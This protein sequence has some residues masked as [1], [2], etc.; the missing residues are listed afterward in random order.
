MAS[1]RNSH[2][3]LKQANQSVSLDVLTLELNIMRATSLSLLLGWLVLAGL[4]LNSR[5]A[6]PA[7][8]AA[9][10]AI[11]KLGG[12]MS[13]QGDGW[14]VEF[15]HRGRALTDEGL[16]HVAALKNV[17]ALNLRDTK[18]T[19]AGLA[20]LK[21][22][23][24]LRW[25]HLERTEVGDAGIE[26]LASLDNL[27]YLNLY[28]TK[29][30]DKSLDDLARLKKLQRLYVWRTDV[31]DAGVAKL[32]KALPELKIVRG[33]DLANLKIK[34]LPKP[35]VPKPKVDLKWIATTDADDAPI[36][37]QGSNTQVFFENKS[38]R[39]VKLFWVGYDG[40][41]R[42]YGELAP[43]A[44]RQLNTYSRNTWLITDEGENPLGYFRVG[45]EL[46][47]AV[48]PAKS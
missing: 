40:K 32:A 7:D 11:K 5:A 13:R 29:I 17:A 12:L 4:P 20:H 42:L 33:V 8:V 34:E 22:L 44:T 28:G 43:G 38:K 23:T 48:I 30:T 41:L 35:D 3:G 9:K 24:T 2:R 6:D 27:E 19:S 10:A 16:L 1:C 15:Q 25:L 31:T 39:I 14:D 37:T 46:S 18:I 45:L 47:R 26:H 36:S 21:D